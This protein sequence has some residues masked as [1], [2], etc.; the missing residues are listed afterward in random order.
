MF[1]LQ[2]CYLS[3]ATLDKSRPLPAP[4]FPHLSNGLPYRHLFWKVVLRIRGVGNA[5]QGHRVVPSPTRCCEYE[6]CPLFTPVSRLRPPGSLRHH[7][8]HRNPKHPE[9]TFRGD[10]LSPFRDALCL[11]GWL[12]LCVS[13]SLR[14]CLNPRMLPLIKWVFSAFQESVLIPTKM[15]NSQ[16]GDPLLSSRESHSRCFANPCQAYVL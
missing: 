13:H 14:I 3:C 12:Q 7:I 2:V 16:G 4:W 6:L 11:R 15:V 8:G 9:E 10:L 5:R 1:Q